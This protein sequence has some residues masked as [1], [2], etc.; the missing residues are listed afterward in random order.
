MA[1]SGAKV[2]ILEQES[3]FKDR[4]RGEFISPWG[5][6]EAKRL[7]ILDVLCNSCATKILWIDMGPGP[8]DVVATTMQKLPALSYS[9][10]EMQETL[11]A[12]AEK[13]GAAVR[14][15]VRVQ[16]L[17]VGES[18]MVVAANGG[19]PE[20]ISARLVVAAD[21]R[22]SLMRKLA[23]FGVERD[24]HPFLMAGVLLSGLPVQ[25]D[26]VRIVFN[27]ELGMVASIMPQSGGRCRSY[28]GYPATMKYRL[29]GNDS[30]DLFL[31]EVVRA[32]PMFAPIYANAKS[33]G[34]LA[35]FDADDCWAP[36]PYHNGVAL[37]GDAAATSDPSYGQG[38]SLALRDARVLRDCLVGD[39]DWERA[40]NRYAAEHDSYFHNCHTATTWFR[41]VFQEQTPE[42]ILRR[43]KAMPLIMQDPMRVPDHL[44]S[45]PE[46]PLNDE[47]RA[48]FF[49]EA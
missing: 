29:Q 13:A 32:I 14:R 44:F 34:P 25:E 8:R 19:A 11:L 26:M 21:G 47:V 6:E 23:G 1:E 30:F 33:I 41:S 18:P 7:D 39:S 49:G 2:L 27:P 40:A 28:L 43:Q 20:R 42:A 3:R 15:G 38:M 9:H 31:S 45:G 22:G 4:I 24:P 10:P 12:A 35:S 46:L 37:I 5:V 16:G 48:R 17:E 36:H